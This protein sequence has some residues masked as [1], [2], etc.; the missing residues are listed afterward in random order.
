[1]EIYQVPVGAMRVNCYILRDSSGVGMIVDPGGETP[2]NGSDRILEACKEHSVDVRLIILTH[3]H[4]DHMLSL[5]AVR[6]ATNAPLA[7]H[8]DDAPALADP[9]ISYMAQYAGKT[10]PMKPAERL[11]S[12]GDIIKLGDSEL[13]VLHTPGHTPGSCVFYF[14]K[15]KVLFS[16]DTIFRGTCGRTDF[17]MSSEED[18]K[19]SLVKVLSSLPEDVTVY[20]GHAFPTTVENEKRLWL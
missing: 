8:R 17:P 20:P 16:G 11:L 3:A 15:E 2:Q 7:L 18:M 1:M 5:E 9:Y 19:K 14:E 12:D 6:R 10:S 13:K 4:F